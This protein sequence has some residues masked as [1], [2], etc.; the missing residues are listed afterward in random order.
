MPPSIGDVNGLS[1]WDND[2]ERL[3][4]V[5]AGV[6]E[7]GSS[8]LSQRQLRRLALRGAAL[9]L[10]PVQAM[11]R[12]QGRL[13][14]QGGAAA[15]D[16]LLHRR[17]LMS[18]SGAGDGAPGTSRRPEGLSVQR[19]VRAGWEL[20]R[21][22]AEV[23]G[24][25]RCWRVTHE[26]AR[27]DPADQPAARKPRKL[28]E[29]RAGF[30]PPSDGGIYRLAYDDVVAWAEAS[31]DRNAIHLLPGSAA[32]LGLEAGPGDVVAHGLVLGALSLAVARPSPHQ[33][34]RL[35]FIGVVDV[36]AHCLGG[37]EA[38]TTLVVDPGSGDIAQGGR[39]VLRR[40]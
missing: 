30:D 8:G 28:T 18:P 15:W 17:C 12:F 24:V 25:G 7:T 4:A 13:R 37:G 39:L 40:R 26:L 21:V 33:Q 34:I 11:Q 14:A 29:S 2:V 35:R 1:P 10:P 38:W 36:P 27:R 9:S 6:L 23:Q 16:G 32:E 3:A 19:T 31:G 20:I 22:T 5:L